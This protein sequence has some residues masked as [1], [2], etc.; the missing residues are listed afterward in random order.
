MT[1]RLEEVYAHFSCQTGVLRFS[2]GLAILA[3]TPAFF[4]DVGFASYSSI[5]SAS[6]VRSRAA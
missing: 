1:L 2:H 6:L 3:F 5:L 4:L